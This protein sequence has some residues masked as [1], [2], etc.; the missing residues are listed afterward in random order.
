M[1]E[2]YNDCNSVIENIFKNKSSSDG[3]SSSQ[4]SDS[5]EILKRPNVKRAK[6]FK[7]DI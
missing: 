5:V 6:V 1:K 2:K 7:K 4:I 3:T